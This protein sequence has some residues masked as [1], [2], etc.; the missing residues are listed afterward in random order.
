MNFKRKSTVGWSIQ[1]VLLDFTGGS[2][3]VAQLCLQ[4]AVRSD[5]TQISGNPV[6]FGLGFVS[7]LF[8]IGFMV[9][10]YG[11]YPSNNALVREREQPDGA[12]ERP[13]MQSEA[14]HLLPAAGSDAAQGSHAE[15]ADSNQLQGQEPDSK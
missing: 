6:K 5:W 12:T 1:N 10:H 8:D 4:C 14:E 3:S 11:L 7:M 9:Q 2:L 13:H 15:T